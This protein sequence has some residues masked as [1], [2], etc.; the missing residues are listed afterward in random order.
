V[1]HS[2][3]SNSDNDLCWGAISRAIDQKGVKWGQNR[4]ERRRQWSWGEGEGEGGGG[5][6]TRLRL[7]MKRGESGEIP[8]FSFSFFF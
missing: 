8:R 7:R 4:D 3:A 1:E 6:A 5:E 2:E